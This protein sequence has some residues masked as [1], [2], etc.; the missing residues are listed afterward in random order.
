M[1]NSQWLSLALCCAFSPSI[2]SFSSIRAL[3]RRIHGGQLFASTMDSSSVSAATLRSLTLVHFPKD[4]NPD[5]LCDFLMEI[6]ACSTSITDSDRGTDLEV[7]LYDEPTAENDPWH[8]S[9]NW[10]M[11]VWNRCNVTAHFPASID[12]NGVLDM[13]QTTF[14][15][16]EDLQL[17]NYFLDIV[18]DRDWVVH[19]Q[20]SWSPIVVGNKIVLRFPWHTDKD[21][22]KAIKDVDEKEKEGLVELQLEGGIAFGT[23]EHPTTQLCLEF[24]DS[25]VKEELKDGDKLLKVLDYGAGSG[26]LGMAACKLAP[27]SV[28]AVGVDIDFDSCRIANVNADTNGVSMR[29]YLPSLSDSADDESMSLLLKAHKHAKARLAERGDSGADVF[30]PANL[31]GSIYDIAVANIL[32]GPLVALSSTIAA[33]IRPGARLGMSGIL[34]QQAEMIIEAYT[35]AGFEDMKLEAELGGWILVTGRKRLSN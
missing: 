31:E 4:Q 15:D 21:V 22:E 11:P 26:V 23:G 5:L 17:Q 24:I 25:A 19:V 8:D 35:K 3:E 2:Q 6:G 20:K 1:V 10:A 16:G 7:P 14:S 34:P 30:L 32:A 33:M 28:S 13:I 9:E 29:S 12:I 27:S 18:P